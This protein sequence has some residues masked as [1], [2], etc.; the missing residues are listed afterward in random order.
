MITA[1]IGVG[2]NQGNPRAQVMQALAELAELP[3]TRLAARSPL[4]GSAPLDAPGQ[5]DF[6]NAVA[7]VDTELSAAQLL[8]ALQ[9]IESRH[10]RERAYR[11]APRTLDLDL[12]LYGEAAFASPVLTLPHPR[13][14]ERA[15]VLRPL[16]DLD[17]RAEVPGRGSARELLLACAAQSVER[18]D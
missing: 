10:G 9:A 12:L 5:P 1:Y 6:V 3:A 2:S 17:P 16:L 18:I 14:H 11:N 7:A 15:F 13:M 8:E 4:Y